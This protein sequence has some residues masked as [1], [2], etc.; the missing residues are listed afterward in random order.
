MDRLAS[1]RGNPSAG[2]LTPGNVSQ[3]PGYFDG[4]NAQMRERST[5]G[6]ASATGSVGGRTTWASSSDVNDIDKMS[7][8]QDETNDGTSSMGGFSDEGNASLV[9]FGEGAASVADGPMSAVSGRSRPGGVASSAARTNMIA[10]YIHQQSRAPPG[11]V[12]ASG[13]APQAH[14]AKMR[15]STTPD[16]GQIN[17]DSPSPSTHERDANATGVETAERIVRERLDEG[18]CNQKMMSTR[19]ARADADRI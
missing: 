6:S 2:N 12:S 11:M 5:V 9:G 19:E 4:S 18:K 14:D 16:V 10:S 3:P 7:E 8:D 17:I 15:D 1:V 13:T